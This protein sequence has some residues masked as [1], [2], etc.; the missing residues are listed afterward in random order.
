MLQHVDIET[1]YFPRYDATYVSSIVGVCSEA[2]IKPGVRIAYTA[3]DSLLQIG[4][5]FDG[6]PSY[7]FSCR[8]SQ[9]LITGLFG[10]KVRGW[11]RW[12]LNAVHCTSSDGTGAEHPSGL[13]Y[14]GSP[15]PP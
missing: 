14:R 10:Q 15:A 8:G 7:S 5:Q 4:Q 3:S 12:A 1:L 11:M 13:R 2:R 6:A 9:S